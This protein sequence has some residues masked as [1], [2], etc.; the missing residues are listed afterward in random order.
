MNSKFNGHASHNAWNVSL[1]V[2][3]D[4]GLY[5]LAKAAIRRTRS[6]TAAARYML[7]SL[8]D[9]GSCKTPDGSPYTIT[10]LRAA[11]VGM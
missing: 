2:N 3:N 9:C 1:W 7:T 5:T 10:S 6:R 11:M 8:T 4:E